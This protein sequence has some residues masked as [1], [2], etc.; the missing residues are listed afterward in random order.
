MK[1][2]KI[3]K[4]KPTRV[5][6]QTRPTQSPEIGSLH[7]VIWGIAVIHGLYR[8]KFGLHG[9]NIRVISGLYRFC[10]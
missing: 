5:L 4:L 6:A 10:V 7:W 8:G 1:D 9:G 2:I 3:E